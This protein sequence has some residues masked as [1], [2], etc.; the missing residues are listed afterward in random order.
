MEILLNI[1]PDDKKQAYRNARRFH[2]AVKQ[3]ILLTTLLMFYAGILAGMYYMLSLQLN[4]L[5]AVDSSETQQ[6]V[7]QE[8]DS[9]NK[10]IQDAN[11]R[12][13]KVAKFQTE[14]TVWSGVLLKLTE[15]IPETITVNMISTKDL[16]ISISGKSE[17]RESLLMFQDKLKQADCFQNP[18]LPLSDLFSQTDV[19]FQMDIEVKQTC[20][21]PHS[22]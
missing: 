9:N 21:K 10:T 7:F 11:E 18:Q 3:G 8:I 20:L 19:D 15:I 4:A 22:L 2:L 14:H 5:Q 16:V 6:A 13:A 17:T 12:V 1:L